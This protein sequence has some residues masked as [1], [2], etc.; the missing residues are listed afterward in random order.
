MARVIPRER[1]TTP[2]RVADQQADPGRGQV[3]QSEQHPGEQHHDHHGTVP[4]QHGASTAASASS[5]APAPAGATKATEPT[6]QA[7]P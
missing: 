7:S 3:D 4:V 2:V 1:F 5:R 6:L